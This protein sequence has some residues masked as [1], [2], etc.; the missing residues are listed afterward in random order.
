MYQFPTRPE[1]SIRLMTFAETLTSLSLSA[2]RH[3]SKQM[4][5]IKDIETRH[6]YDQLS[7]N[8]HTIASLYEEIENNKQLIATFGERPAHQ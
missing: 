1:E 5:R 6:R 3:I 7:E 4:K 2:A 8:A